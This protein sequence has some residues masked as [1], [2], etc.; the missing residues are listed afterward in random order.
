VLGYGNRLNTHG[1]NLLSAPGNDL[2]ASTAL[3]AAGCHLVLF[4]TGRGTPFGTFVPTMKI[5]TNSD[6]AHRKPT[7][8]D[9]DAGVLLNDATWDDTL[10]SF[11]DKVIATCN[12]APTWNERKHYQEIAIFKRGVTL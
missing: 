7:W 5:S 9:F 6:L 2:V 12:G 1:L 8:I 10:A 11:I 3:A 4:T